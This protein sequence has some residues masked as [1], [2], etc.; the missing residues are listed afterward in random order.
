MSLGE[1]RLS[2]QRAC[3]LRGEGWKADDFRW[4]QDSC[5][6][7]LELEVGPLPLL[8]FCNVMKSKHDSHRTELSAEL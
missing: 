2:T 8:W 1:E 4:W 5:D 3:D 6:A 7:F